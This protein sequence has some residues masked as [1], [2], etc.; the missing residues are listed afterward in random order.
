MD[1]WYIRFYASLFL[2]KKINLFPGVTMV[3]NSGMDGSGIH[4]G[5]ELQKTNN[6]D[7]GVTPIKIKNINVEESESVYQVFK[8]FYDEQVHI[9]TFKKHIMNLKSFV[10]RLLYLDCL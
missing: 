4:C 10:R 1:S 3:T 9:P 8:A 5:K 7:L 2:N 6:F